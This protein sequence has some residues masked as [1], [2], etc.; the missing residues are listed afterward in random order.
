MWLRV[1]PTVEAPSQARRELS[2]L[3]R[4]VDQRTLSDV[5]TVISELVG[6]SVAHGARKP[7][8]V[9]LHL[10]DGGLE[11]VVDDDGTGA[12]AISRR[13]GALVLRILEGLVEE[14]GTNDSGKRI[15]FRMTVRPA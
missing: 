6:M 4:R 13:E 11:G 2:A 10:D 5:T 9:S 15:W 3:A 8:E 1:F 7:I 14:W 12:R